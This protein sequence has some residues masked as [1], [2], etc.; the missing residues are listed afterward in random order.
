MELLIQENCEASLVNGLKNG[1]N[2]SFEY[3]VREYGG[4]MMTVTRRYLK[5]EADVQDSVQESFLQAYNAIQKFEARSTVKSWLHRIAVNTALMRIRASS[6]RPEGLID[7]T[8]SLFDDNGNRLESGIELL[9]SVESEAIGTQ[10][11]DCVRRYIQTLPDLSRDLLMLRD[12]EGYSTEE[13]A[14]LMSM[15]IASVKTG[16]HR[17][18]RALKQAIQEG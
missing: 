1:D 8:P 7:D 5:S 3:L 13:T 18:R 11:R 14:D 6:R 9:P 10:T 17:A 12:I 15:S 4:Y 16:L 2:A